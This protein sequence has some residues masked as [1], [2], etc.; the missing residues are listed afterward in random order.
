ETCTVPYTT[1]FRS[2]LHRG[3]GVD[4]HRALDA[5][6]DQRLFRTQAG[7]GLTL[8][9]GAH[10][11][12]V[13]VVVLEEGNQ[14][15]GHGHDLRR[16]NVHVVNVFR[17]GHERF[18]S[19]T[20]SH[21]VVDKTAFFVQLGVRLS[22][23]VVAFLDRG[24]IV[25]LV[26]DLAV[27]DLVVRRFQEAVIIQARIQRHGVDQTDVRAFRRFDRADA[28]VVG[29]VHVA[30][31]ETGALAGQ[32]ARSQGRDTTLVRDLGQRVGLVHELR[33]LARTE[34]LLDGRRNRLGV[35]QVVRH[36]VFGFGLA[37]AFLN[38]TLDTHQT[39]AELVLG[40]FANTRS[41]EHTS[42]L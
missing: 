22:D 36:Q 9:V 8:H 18:T 21:Q 26:A 40:Q 11:S 19:L 33:Q 41:E 32:T 5:G 35:D 23:D 6:A 16:S 12:P 31:F 13:R 38:C 10:Q 28:A 15:S 3:A 7:Y 17:R 39:C 34:E 37:E 27:D 30:D 1:L 20:A 25:D 42:E 29:R 2:R 24:E 4:G 14:R